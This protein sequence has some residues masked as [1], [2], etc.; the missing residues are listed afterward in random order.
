MSNESEINREVPSS[1]ND[2]QYRLLVEAVTDYA[3]YML[4]PN[5]IVVSWNAGAERFKGYAS[6]EVVG[7]HFSI[8]YTPQ[9]QANGEPRRALDTALSEG[10]FESEGW[11]IRKDGSRFWAS[12]IV[13]PIR[14]DGQILGFAKVTRDISERKEAE[15]ALVQANAALLQAQKVEAVGQM[16]A[17]L[18]HDFS[19]LLG[20]V[21][22]SLELLRKRLPSDPKTIRLL[23][24]AVQGAHRG[25]ALTQR[26]LAF[27]RRQ[28]LAPE[29]VDLPTLVRGMTMLMEPALGARVTVTVHLPTELNAVLVDPNQLE[30]AILNLAV[31]ARDAMADGGTIVIDVREARL[32]I[33]QVPGLAAGAYGCLSVTD[34]GVGMDEATLSRA[35]EPFYTT[36]GP[37]Q[38]TGLGLSVVHGIAIQANGRLI[39]KSEVGRG[40]TAELWL[41]LTETGVATTGAAEPAPG[42]LAVDEDAL[43]PLNTVMLL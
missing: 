38:G 19:H 42:V 39:L 36:K 9:D 26:L 3:I 7:R 41:P 37:G 14:K 13:E 21:L 40:T 27:A 16:T 11:R 10:R 29:A 28:E 4:D 31:N 22:V 8:F 32:V 12:V 23:E 17:G 15:R 33:G 20:L 18:A 43:V 30:M 24:N 2:G 34:S 25:T 6:S 35:M 5:G 1:V